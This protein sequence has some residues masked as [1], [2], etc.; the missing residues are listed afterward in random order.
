MLPIWFP[1]TSN[2]NQQRRRGDLRGRK[3]RR[4][5]KKQGVAV[6]EGGRE[7]KKKGMGAKKESGREGERGRWVKEGGE[8]ESR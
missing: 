3:E 4:K 6:R 8:S 5:R 2:S 7:G 1:I